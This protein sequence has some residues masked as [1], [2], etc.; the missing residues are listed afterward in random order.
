MSR[1]G[2]SPERRQRQ[3]EAIQKWKPWDKS[4]GPKTKEG[5]T[6]AAANSHKHGLYDAHSRDLMRALNAHLREQRQMLKRL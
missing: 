3:R 4:T 6:K 1:K 5:K 2:W